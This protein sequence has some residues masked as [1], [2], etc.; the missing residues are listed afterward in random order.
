MFFF[1]VH[2]IAKTISAQIQIFQLYEDITGTINQELIEGEITTENMVGS[3][4]I[5]DKITGTI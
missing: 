4:L 2:V 5:S 1:V 3:I